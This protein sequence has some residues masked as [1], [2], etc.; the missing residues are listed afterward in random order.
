MGLDGFVI[1][2]CYK[3][4]RSAPFPLPELERYFGVDADGYL[5]LKL[6]YE[7]NEAAFETVYHWRH[8]A[9]PDHPDME[10]ASEGVANWSGYRVFLRALEQM[11]WHHFP[12]LKT[13]LPTANQGTVPAVAAAKALQELRYFNNHASWGSNIFLIDTLTGELLSDY[14]EAYNGVFAFASSVPTLQSGIDR[15]GFFIAETDGGTLLD[16]GR[17]FFQ[18]RRFE[19][20]IVEASDQG[21]ATR[22]QYRDLDSERGYESDF[23]AVAKLL[24][25]ADG[26]VQLDYPRLLHV[27]T[28]RAQAERFAYIVDPLTRLF[29]ASVDTGNPVVWC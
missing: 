14:I 10:A 18:A 26:R 3:E 28:R 11:G 13:W 21:L 23:G 29:R 4:G 17:R 27:E 25:D 9:C 8:D 1:C 20:Y 22:V 24:R 6:P 12:T 5:S 19:Q 2:N 7:G 15:Q 16:S